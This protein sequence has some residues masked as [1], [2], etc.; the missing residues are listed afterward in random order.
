MKNYP[1]TI[2]EILNMFDDQRKKTIKDL[3]TLINNTIPDA[4]ETVKQGNIIY[5]LNDKNLL[6]I[7]N[8]KNHVDLGFFNG[9]KLSSVIL[10]SRGSRKTWRHIEIKTS[11]D[12]NDP[13]ITRLLE[14]SAW[15]FT[16]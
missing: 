14:K 2:E 11:E 4:Q 12:L 5:T 3:Q 7:G 9:D 1:K 15:L 6:R 16:L 13:E 8:F 10:K